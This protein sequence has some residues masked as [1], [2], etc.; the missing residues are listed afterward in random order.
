MRAEHNLQN[1]VGERLKK[2]GVPNA[3]G[4]K[5]LRMITKLPEMFL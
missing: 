2:L 5:L 3:N 1:H 4:E